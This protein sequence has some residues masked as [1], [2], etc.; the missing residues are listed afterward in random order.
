MADDANIHSEDVIGA[1]YPF[2][3]KGNVQMQVCAIFALTQ[4]GS[5]AFAQS[6]LTHF[7]QLIEGPEFA[8]GRKCK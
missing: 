2:L 8:T 1:S 6:Q 7:A 4:K 5:Y 3:K